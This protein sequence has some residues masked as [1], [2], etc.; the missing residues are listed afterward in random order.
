MNSYKQTLYGPTA[1]III[2]PWMVLA[3]LFQE[4]VE[5]EYEDSQVL[6]SDFKRNTAQRC[7]LFFKICFLGTAA[8]LILPPSAIAIPDDIVSGSDADD[9]ASVDYDISLVVSKVQ[10]LI[11]T[12]IFGT[13]ISYYLSFQICKIPNYVVA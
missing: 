7:N 10:S 1:S 4:M 9:G 13:I 8:G 6:K 11:L 5:K 2:L 12:L 3:V